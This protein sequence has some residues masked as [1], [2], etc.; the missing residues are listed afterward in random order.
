MSKVMIMGTSCL[1]PQLPDGCYL[2]LPEEIYFLQRGRRGSTDLSKLFL[3]KEGWWWSSELNPDRPAETPDEART[4]GKALHALVLEG[5]AAFD[6]RFA[7]SPD[8]E[9]ERKKHGDLFCV[10]KDDMILALEKRQM[11]PKANMPKDQLVAFCVSRAPDLK[12]WDLIEGAWRSANASK[13]PVTEVEHRHLTLMRDVIVN[14]EDIGELFQFGPD[15]VPLSEV[16]VLYTDEYGIKRRARLDEVLPQTIIDLKTLGNVGSQPL[17]FAVGD[18]VAKEA[19]HVQFADH[20]VGRK[21][22]YRFITEGKL[23][24]GTPPEL[25]SPATTEKFEREAGWLKRFP[26]E[27]PSWDYAWLFFQKPDAKRGVA[28]IVFPWGEDLGSDLHMRGIRCRREAI[29][30]YRRCMIQFGPDTPWTRVEPVH[31]TR[32]GAPNQVF[33]PHFIG[34]DEPLPNEEDDL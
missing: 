18:R 14:H 20:H 8:K 3:R 15:H 12:I 2:N 5:Q 10:T 25:R 1:V 31:M 7:I 29:D 32:E 19:Y 4:F 9:V 26:V 33:V 6:E 24:D 21:M 30:T 34:G 11:H 13:L 16:S 27:A 23:Y 28:P 22:A 17:K